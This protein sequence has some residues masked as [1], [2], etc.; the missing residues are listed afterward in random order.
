MDEYYI[1]TF[2]RIVG[3]DKITTLFRPAVGKKLPTTALYCRNVSLV[4]NT[5]ITDAIFERIVLDFDNCQ[6]HFPV[7]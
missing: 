7:A 6:W 4:Y 2:A 3:A 5:N 1:C